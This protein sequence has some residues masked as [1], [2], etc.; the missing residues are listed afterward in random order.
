MSPSTKPIECGTN[1]LL[2]KRCLYVWSV[3]EFVDIC[4]IFNYM[5]SDI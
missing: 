2:M 4:S 5:L 1:E 3:V